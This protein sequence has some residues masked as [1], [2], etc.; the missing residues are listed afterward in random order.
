MRNMQIFTIRTLLFYLSF[1]FYHI[2]TSPHL[3]GLAQAIAQ[4]P[5]TTKHAAR[6]TILKA[7]REFDS[8][9]IAVIAAHYHQQQGTLLGQYYLQTLYVAIKQFA[10]QHGFAEKICDLSSAAD[11]PSFVKGHMYEVETALSLHDQGEKITHFGYSFY[12]NHTHTNRSIDIA[13]TSQLIECKNINWKSYKNNSKFTRKIK[14]QLMSYQ[15]LSLENDDELP[16]L[17][18]SKQPITNDWKAWLDDN[19]IEYKEDN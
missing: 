19:N 5:N 1:L 8:E 12:C 17:L 10:T 16:F 2:Q 18:Y 9:R 4:L 15:T 13:T 14:R 7:C 6:A 3:L 11:T